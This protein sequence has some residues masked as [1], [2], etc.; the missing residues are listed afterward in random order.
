M[1]VVKYWN[2]LSGEVWSFHL[3][4]FNTQLYVA[5]SNVLQLTLLEERGWTR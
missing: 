2:R 3:W 5:L 1:R 4:R